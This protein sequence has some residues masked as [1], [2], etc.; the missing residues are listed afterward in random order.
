MHTGESAIERRKNLW[1]IFSCDQLKGDIDVH[2][3]FSKVAGVLRSYKELSGVIRSYK[4]SYLYC[5]L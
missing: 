1:G 5:I 4:E 3:T 2:H